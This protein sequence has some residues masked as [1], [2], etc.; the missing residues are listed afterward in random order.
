MLNWLNAVE[1]KHEYIQQLQQVISRL[2]GCESTW[3]QSV[4]VHETFR[5][6]TVWKSDVEVFSVQHAEAKTAY[7]WA[8]PEGEF[9]AVLGLPPVTDPQKAVWAWIVA[10]AKHPPDCLHVWLENG[11]CLK[12]GAQNSSGKPG[13]ISNTGQRVKSSRGGAGQ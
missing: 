5:G 11:L 13:S 12:C 10:S 1:S 8:T 2:H 4:P 9:T 3:V 7:A 6:L